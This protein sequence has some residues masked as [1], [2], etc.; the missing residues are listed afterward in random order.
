[1][2]IAERKIVMRE[3]DGSLKEVNLPSDKAIALSRFNTEISDQESDDP[4]EGSELSNGLRLWTGI[5]YLD[6]NQ[7]RTLAEECVKQV[8]QRGPFL[9]LSEFINR[10]L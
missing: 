4:E 5:R 3:D 2:G 6:E 7:V 1:M 8:K 10:R 9:N